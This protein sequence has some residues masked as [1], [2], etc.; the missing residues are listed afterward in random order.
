M[1]LYPVIM[2]VDEVSSRL[3]GKKKVE[4]LSAI[5]REAL[6]LSANKSG[7]ALGELRKDRDDRP[8]PFDGIY[9]SLSHK[10]KYVAAVLC[11][12]KI[13]IDIEEIKPRSERFFNKTASAKEWDLVGGKNW[14]NFYRYWTAK[15]SVLKA[16]GLGIG[17]LLQCRITSV[18]NDT[19]IEI[20]YK[21]Q[22]FKIEQL[23]YRDHIVSVVKNDYPVEWIV[24]HGVT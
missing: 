7:I 13:G 20:F 16:D 23:Y 4:R 6:R 21:G 2:P 10:S 5:A 24:I 14:C 11:T 12:E 8:V 17:G 3:F 9:W 1:T 19:N 15:E 18:L 22:R